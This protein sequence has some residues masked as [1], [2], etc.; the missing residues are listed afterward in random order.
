M[1]LIKKLILVFLLFCGWTVA[2]A[3]AQQTSEPAGDGYVKGALYIKFKDDINKF[4][5]AKSGQGRSVETARLFPASKAHD[6]SAF[7]LGEKA[8]SLHLFG[9]EKLQNCYRIDFSRFD[10]TEDLMAL[11]SAL[12]SVEY[13]EQVPESQLFSLPN[14]PL[15]NMQGMADGSWHLKQIGFEEIYGQYHGNPDIKVAVVD[16]AIWAD[17]PDLNILPENRYFGFVDAEGD[18]NPPAEIDQDEN[19][20]EYYNCP[21]FKWSH[22]THCAGLIAAVN[23]NNEG[24]ASFASGVTLLAARASDLR[25]DGVSKGYECILWA[26]DKGAR[27]ISC[28]WGNSRTTATEKNIIETGVKNGIIFMVAAGNDNTSMQFYP[29]AYEGTIAIGSVDS[30]NSRSVFSNYGAWVDFA[31]PGGAIV[32]DGK[33]TETRLLSTT[34]CASQYYRLKGVTELSGKYYDGNSGTSMATPLAASVVSLMLSVNPDLTLTDVK[35]ILKETATPAKDFDMA[36]GGGVIN[37]AAAVRKAAEM[38]TANARDLRL[39]AGQ[40]S[41]YPNPAQDVAEIRCPYAVRSL[42]I[43]DLAGKCLRQVA[44]SGLNPRIDLSGLPTGMLMV[45][46]DTE[47]GLLHAKIV[48]R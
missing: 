41:V 10:K 30:D 33:E 5:P 7:G 23:D 28:S 6:L 38:K 32:K 43:Y 47:Q 25:G 37:A 11:L 36:E 39:D 13:V 24:I 16:N 1:N 15:F 48:K 40:L 31:A 2:C 8:F 45:A 46:A 20:R 9:S 42:R 4:T 35:K 12:P 22:G 14:D 17:H 27:V 34:Y 44:V 21:A 3:Y 29:A 18:C 26:I 19:C